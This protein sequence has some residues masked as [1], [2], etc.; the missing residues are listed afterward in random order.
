[1]EPDQPSQSTDSPTENELIS[2]EEYRHPTN[3]VN[4]K[5]KMSFFTFDKFLIYCSEFQ[6]LIYKTE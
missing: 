2:T 6:F 4:T 3:E 1:M 5:V